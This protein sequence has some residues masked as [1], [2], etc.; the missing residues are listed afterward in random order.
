MTQRDRIEDRQDELNAAHADLLAPASTARP[1]SDDNTVLARM[2]Q[3]KKGAQIDA[4]YRGQWESTHDSQSE[5]DLAL[6]S[7]LAYWANGDAV[8]M[9][10]LFRG[11]GLM[12]PKWDKRHH[13]DGRKYGQGTIDQALSDFTPRGERIPPTDGP[14]RAN[15]IAPDGDA[16]PSPSP[17]FGLHDVGNAERLLHHFGRDLHYVARWNRWLIWDGHR[18]KEDYTGKVMH[19]ARKTAGMI[20]GEARALDPEAAQKLGKW[21]AQSH[22]LGRLKAMVELA[23][24]FQ[25][26]VLDPDDLDAN[27]WLLTC[28]NGTLD[29]RTGELRESRR[30]DLCTKMTPVLY[31]PDA[32]CPSWLIFLERVLPDSDT[33]GYLQRRVGYS[34]TGDTNERDFA[35]LWGG[36][37]NGKSTFVETIQ[38]L[39]GDF[40]IVTPAASLMNQK[41]DTIRNDIAALKGA[42]LV[43]AHESEQDRYLAEGLVKS[44]TGQDTIAARFLYGEMFRFKPVFKLWLHTNHAPLIRGTDDAIWDRLRLVPF[45][46]RIPVEERDGGLGDRLRREELSGILTW[47]M[48]GCLD[49]Q[50]HGLEPPPQVIA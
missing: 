31:D 29:L 21:A 28:G 25:E 2:N 32:L 18:W 3:S 37:K 41:H 34:L 46:V 7:H 16:A 35:V 24:T 49:W 40:S 17:H 44:L 10:R 15:G 1:A 20:W 4:L 47:A 19:L 50:Q 39:L 26:I 9:D 45:T 14:V 33:R 22:S 13:A 6:C 42:R 43:T 27:A 5:A 36:G 11:S 12:R 8:Q 23:S 30:D 48:Q 38:A